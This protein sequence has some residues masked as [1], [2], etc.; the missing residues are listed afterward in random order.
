MVRLFIHD[1]STV[2]PPCGLCQWIILTP[3]IGCKIYQNLILRIELLVVR[4]KLKVQPKRV[5]MYKIVK[6]LFD[7]NFFFSNIF[8]PLITLVLYC[9]SFS[10]FSSRFLLDG[11]NQLF[12]SKLGKYTLMMTVAMGLIF[13]VLLKTN[14]DNKL[15]FK[16]ALEKFYFDDLILLLFP[17]TPVLQYV[18]SNQDLLSP[19]DSLYVLIAFLFF[20]SLYI[21][22]VPMLLGRVMPVRTLMALGL[23]FVFTI[24]NMASLSDYFNW[25]EKGTLRIQLMFFG[26][27]FLA[28]W[29]LYTFN[30]RKL[31]HL[32]I[33]LNFFVNGATQLLL[34]NAAPN[35]PSPVF[36]ENKLLSLVETKSP[37]VTPNIYLLVYDAYVPSETLSGYGIDNSSQEDFLS[38]QGFQ[39]YPHTYSIGSSTLESMSKVLNAS[40]EYY[41]NHRRGAS[42]DGVVQKLLHDIGYKTYGLFYSDYMFRGYGESYDYSYPEN[43]TPAYIQLLKAI[44]IGEFRFNIEKV[45]FRDQTREQFVETKRKA[46]EQMP[47]KQIF[48]YMH[49]DLPAHSQNSGACLANEVE[50]FKKRLADANI[51]MQGDVNLIVQNDPDAIVIVA[52]DHGPYLTKNCSSL[53]NSYDISEISRLDIQDRHGDFL[54]IRWPTGDFV[55]YDDITVLQ[56]LFPSVF[57]YLYKDNTILQSKIEPIIPIPNRISGVTVDNGVIVGGIND[58]EFL[59]LSGR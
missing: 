13:L 9:A 11:V 18:L 35:V 22:A 41:G 24:A 28:A 1:I 14:K 39:L 47:G 7:V 34:R 55:K 36:Q 51:E 50:L 57:A 29:A 56:D 32:F 6:K 40:T 15:K 12:A 8:V 37:V 54:A 2:S 43:S 46:F 49:S 45:G 44:S 42:G 27:S 59:F 20:S 30:Q 38:A 17:L 21:F 23:A 25:F 31:L 58:G 3:K 53:T 48:V 5:H 10:Y 52:G 19:A 16:D 4:S 33:V 26:G